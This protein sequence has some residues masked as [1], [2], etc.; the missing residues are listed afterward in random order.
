MA[1]FSFSSERLCIRLKQCCKVLILFLWNIVVVLVKQGQLA[2]RSKVKSVR[3]NIYE[4]T[5][6]QL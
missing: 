2:L 1:F 5:F 6:T 3:G 4:W